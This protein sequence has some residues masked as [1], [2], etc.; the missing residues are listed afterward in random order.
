MKSRYKNYLTGNPKIKLLCY[1]ILDIDIKQLENCVKNITSKHAIKNNVETIKINSLLE[2]KN[3]ILDCYDIIKNH[4]CNCV[5]CNKKY[6][7]NNIDKHLCN[8]NIEFIS[9]KKNKIIKK[10]S[11]KNNKNIK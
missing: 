2:L 11:K 5:I 1:A 10:N 9:F 3:I 6:K 7:F 4:T 8:N